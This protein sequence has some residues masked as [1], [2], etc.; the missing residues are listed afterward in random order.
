MKDIKIETITLIKLIALKDAFSIARVHSGCV[1]SDT[2]IE[3]L[4]NKLINS[5][6]EFNMLLEF[7]G[8]YKEPEGFSEEWTDIEQFAQNLFDTAVGNIEHFYR[9]CK[10]VYFKNNFE[11]IDFDALLNIDDNW[12]GID[13]YFVVNSR[14]NNANDGDVLKL[15][16]ASPTEISMLRHDGAAVCDYKVTEHCDRITLTAVKT[17]KRTYD[18]QDHA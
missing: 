10:Y 16:P 5:C 14:I 2:V 12:F 11:K 6:T 3:A 9:D 7:P 4:R 17:Y 13:D 1:L 8:S 15:D 18:M